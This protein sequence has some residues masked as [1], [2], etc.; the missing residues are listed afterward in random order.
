MRR[1]RD[2]LQGQARGKNRRRRR[3]PMARR[4]GQALRGDRRSRRPARILCRPG[5]CRR[6]RRSGDHQILRRRFRAA[7]QCVAASAV[8][9]ART[10]PRRR[11]R[12]RTRDGDARTRRITGRGSRICARTSRTSSR[13][14]SSSCSTR[15]R[16]TGYAAWNRLFDETIAGLRFK[17]GGKELAIEPT[18]NLLQDRAPAQAQGGGARRWRRPSRPM[19]GPSR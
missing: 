10:Q 1:V 14:A 6:Q 17:V 11:C 8:L 4:G 7:D 3:R 5:S 13:T 12:D 19:S 16:Q 18:L 15:N 2:G 9:R